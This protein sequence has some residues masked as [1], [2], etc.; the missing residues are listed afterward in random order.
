VSTA[1]ENEIEKETAHYTCADYLE[2]DAGERY[3]II[4]GEAYMM[5]AAPTVSRRIISREL[6][7]QF[8]IFFRGKPCQ[9]FTTSLDVR[10]FPREDESDDTIVQPDILVVCDAS[11][12]AD[13]RSCRGVP[14]MVIQAHIL[15]KTG[16][17][18][19][20]R[21]ISAVYENARAL[22]VSI[23][24]GLRIDFNDIWSTL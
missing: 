6:S 3:E 15:E 16:G 11:K 14:D 1:L 9:V 23:L 20:C 8:W 18:A 19:P 24:P 4:D 10:L 2:L 5:P 13:K 17:A 12:L 7:G 21:Y 22:D